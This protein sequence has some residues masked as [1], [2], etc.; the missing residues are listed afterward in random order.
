M[1]GS[2]KSGAQYAS[3]SMSGGSQVQVWKPSN[4]S[5]PPGL[6]V[7]RGSLP[8]TRSRASVQVA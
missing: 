4:V 2:P 7:P 6:A 8:G 5:T 3:A 1:Q